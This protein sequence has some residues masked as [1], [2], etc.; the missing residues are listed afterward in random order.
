MRDPK[1][2]SRIC[3]KLEKAWMKSPDQRLGQFISNLQG[4]G[5]HDVFY[6]EDDEWEGLIDA[7]AEKKRG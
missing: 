4:P 2:I 1:R 6:M 7:L 5:V 3:K